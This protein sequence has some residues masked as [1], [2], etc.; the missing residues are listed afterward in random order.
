M[1][2]EKSCKLSTPLPY[3]TSY[4][5]V[6]IWR[7]TQTTSNTR[8]IFVNALADAPIGNIQQNSACQVTRR[9]VRYRVRLRQEEDTIV[10]LTDACNI[11]RP[12]FSIRDKIDMSANYNT[13][14]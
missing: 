9:A 10:L 14:L 3:N 1:I 7:R 11:S 4:L 6:V 12:P 8:L 2:S 13:Q 5:Y